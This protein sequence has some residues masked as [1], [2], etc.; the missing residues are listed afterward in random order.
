MKDGSPQEGREGQRH[1]RRE[2]GRNGKRRQSD[3]RE[4]RKPK[5]K[6]EATKGNEG[7]QRG[8]ENRKAKEKLIIPNS[9][10]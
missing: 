3:Q 7:K 6:E 10:I 1:G 4:L 9:N 8:E 5:G 2:G